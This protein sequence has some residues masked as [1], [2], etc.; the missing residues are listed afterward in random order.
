[1]MNRESGLWKTIKEAIPKTGRKIETTR[2]ESWATPGVPDVIL[3]SEKGNFSFLELKVVNRRA[4]KVAL[5]AHQ[6]AWAT[7]HAQAAV[8]IV[9]KEPSLSISV[10]P[11]SSVVDLRLNSFSSVSPLSVFPVPYDWEVFFRLTCPVG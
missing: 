4:S 10:F 7:R 9:V 6:C 2:L 1:V 3:C 8:F 11:A 5:S